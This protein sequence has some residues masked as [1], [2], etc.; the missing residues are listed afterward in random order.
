MS[1]YNWLLAPLF[2]IAVTSSDVK[3]GLVVV[4]AAGAGTRMKSDKAK[5][6]HTILGKPLVGHVLD[7]ASQTEPEQTVVVVGHQR[8][9]VAK[10]LSGDYPDVTTAVQDQQNGTGHAVRCAIEPLDRIPAG[11]V[12]VLAGD[13]PLLTS[14]T[15]DDL[16]SD[17][18]RAGAAVTVLTAKVDNPFGY[19]RI[20]RDA[21]G[22][23]ERIVEQKDATEAQRAVDEINSSIYVFDAVVL[24][25][26]LGKL[27]TDNAQGEEYLT[28]VVAIAREAGL[29]V[30]ASIARSSD[31]IRGINDKAQLADAAVI[32]RDRI[33]REHLVN[34]VIITDPATTWIS[35][36]AQLEADAVIERNTSIDASSSVAAGAVVGPDTTL[37][38]TSVAA[39]ACVIRS[40]C[41]HAE[42]GRKASVGPFSF[43]RP[44][45]RLGERA[46]VG[47]YVEIK[48]STIGPAS[49][50]PHL[51]YV[52][53]A[54]IGE[55]TNIG[56]ATIFANYDGEKKHAT[57]I[58]DHVRIGSDS[59]LVAPITIG[60]GAY[61]A[62]G[63]VITEDVEPGSIAIARGRQRNVA[64]WVERA[65]PGSDSAAAA[66]AAKSDAATAE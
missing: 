16:L 38:S 22:N 58:G 48:K 35:P 1:A 21:Q 27:S 6:L 65:R 23:V 59:I 50:V 34:G 39:N 43:L 19:G 66:A 12:L 45:A 55:G 54:T 5:V 2:S 28:E 18:A 36:G 11:P 20:I 61:T 7:A 51:S 25:D 37:I 42:I 26:A 9:A 14:Q 10:Y 17:H 31:E 40:H 46:K 62:A 29:V 8:E 41:D 60:D 64:G 4:L 3:P 53:D 47:A 56:A 32:L 30:A 63:S 44:G 24:V 52:G 33:N 49:K 13:T 15:L 57:V